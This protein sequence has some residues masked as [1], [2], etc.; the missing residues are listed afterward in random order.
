MISLNVMQSNLVQRG[1]NVKETSP[2]PDEIEDKNQ[3]KENSA[4]FLDRYGDYL[5]G[6]AFVRLR[7]AQ[8]AEDVVQE[9]LLKAILNYSKFR[10]DAA[11][12]TWLTSILRNE[13]SSHFRK[14]RRAGN[15]RHFEDEQKLEMGDLLHPHVSNTDFELAIER[16]E[17]W[18]IIQDCYKRVPEHLL[19][20][21]LAKTR[22]EG[23]S[24]QQLC[25]NLGISASNFAVRMFRTRLLLRKCI[26]E[27]WLR[28]R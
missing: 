4:E 2:Q 28:D 27:K 3:G 6:Y 11:V 17:F 14:N 12:K 23:E 18:A 7:D 21:F 22:A 19:Q 24:T 13:I 9:T 8:L 25:N 1:L 20:V 26:E 5:Y 10:G 16:E 15:V